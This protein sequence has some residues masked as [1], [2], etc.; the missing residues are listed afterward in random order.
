MALAGRRANIKITSGTATPSTNNACTRSTGAGASNGHIA[1][2]S[3]TRR[4]W[5]DSASIKLYRAA[6]G[7]TS[8]VGSSQYTVDPVRGRF[9][10][11]TGDPSTGTYTAD[12]SYLT[13]TTLVQGRSWELTAEQE[14]LDTTTFG[15]SGWKQWLPDM[16][17]GTLT[18]GRFWAD[19]TFFDHINLSTKFAV[20]L[21][22]ASTQTW[23]Y[24]G[25]ARVAQDQI[26]VSI[27]QIVSEGVS[28]VIDGKLHYSS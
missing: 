4:H 18:V 22:P 27:G 7:T 20:E 14:L 21:Y 11:R 16:A 28:L 17:G 10:W 12:V 8:L 13:A 23:R 15:S 19:P 25:F 3:T 24:E 6:L 1:I 9:D 5:D 26:G 2:N